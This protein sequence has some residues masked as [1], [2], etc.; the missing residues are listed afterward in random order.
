MEAP[1]LATMVLYHRKRA[2]LSREACA[3]LAG[4]GKTVVYDIE[5]GKTSIRFDTLLKVLWVLN[6]R[7]EFQSPLMKE[8][9]DAKG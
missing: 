7:L 5:H 4:V 9:R 6:I 3:D 2:G 1:D 8:F